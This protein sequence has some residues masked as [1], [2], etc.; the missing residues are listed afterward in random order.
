MMCQNKIGCLSVDFY[1]QWSEHYE[2][3][4]DVKNMERAGKIL[5][6]VASKHIHEGHEDFEK[7]KNARKFLDH[8]MIRK[9][10]LSNQIQNKDENTREKQ[11]LKSLVTTGENKK[12]GSV[13][14]TTMEDKIRVEQRK[15][16]KPQSNT[17]LQVY[18]EEDND[19]EEMF[20]QSSSSNKLSEKHHKYKENEKHASQWVGRT[21]PQTSH[22]SH[23]R[24][25]AFEVYR[26][27]DDKEISQDNKK[28]INKARG[29]SNVEV[30]LS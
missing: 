17:K 25:P 11:T 6:Q 29:I 9:T 30:Y 2:H 14:I 18:N 24:N 3:V 4:G 21:L 19:N 16:K 15:S 1:K 28:G 12:V 23:Q 8:R 13:R 7:L 22:A 20:A 26:D 10:L 5:N 27:E